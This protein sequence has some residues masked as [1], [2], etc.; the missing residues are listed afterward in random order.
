[1]YYWI[2]IITILLALLGLQLYSRSY[3]KKR[4]TG[5]SKSIYIIQFK[6]VDK[7]PD[8]LAN[9]K[10]APSL[11]L[12]AERD[13]EYRVYSK[14]DDTALKQLIRNEYHLSSGQ[15]VISSPYGIIPS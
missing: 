10:I 14:L 13:K 8:I 12:I 3:R 11:E 5:T 15:V 6:N 1:M 2:G 7:R 4:F 9:D